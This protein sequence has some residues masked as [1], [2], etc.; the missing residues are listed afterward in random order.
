M[1]DTILDARGG[2]SGREIVIFGGTSL[3][4]FEYPICTRRG[5]VAR[6]RVRD[7]ADGASSYR[8][9]TLRKSLF[10]IGAIERVTRGST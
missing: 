6:L 4:R 1:S 8:D 5:R 10:E 9:E 7:G 3:S 2:I